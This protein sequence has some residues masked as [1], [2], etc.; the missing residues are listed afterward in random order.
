MIDLGSF[1]ACDKSK[2]VL[3]M[4]ETADPFKNPKKKREHPPS[5]N[6]LMYLL[7]GGRKRGHFKQHFKKKKQVL[8]A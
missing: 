2:N 3:A 8:G 5:G 1:L 6:P 4:R 7:V